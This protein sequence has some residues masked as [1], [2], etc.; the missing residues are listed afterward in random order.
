MFPDGQGVS[1]ERSDEE[2]E[3]EKEEEME[4]EKEE[5][6]GEKEEMEGEKEEEMEGEKEE[7]TVPQRNESFLGT[8]TQEETGWRKCVRGY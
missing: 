3:G 8:E 1:D 2:M 7:D 5:I 6:E 4:G